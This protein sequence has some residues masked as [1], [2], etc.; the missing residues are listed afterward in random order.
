MEHIL[1][2]YSLCASLSLLLFFGFS[3]LYS[4]TPDKAIF[5]NF[6]RSRRIMGAALLLLSVNYSVHLLFEVRYMSHDAA[7]LLNLSTYF[8]C[9]WLFSSALTSLLDRF[10]IT[11]RKFLIH[12]FMWAAFSLLSGIVL[13]VLPAGAAREV[14]LTVMAVWL[15]SYGVVLSRRLLRAYKK[16]VHIIDN[17]HFRTI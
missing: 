1:Y 14:G 9:Y 3:F 10:Y 12:L 6:L 2:S 17:T 8:L 4:K 7:I 16:A 13:F 11:R 15:I 5:A